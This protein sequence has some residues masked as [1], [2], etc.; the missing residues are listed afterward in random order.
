MGLGKCLE[1]LDL[2]LNNPAVK[3][4]IIIIPGSFLSIYKISSANV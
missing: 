4:I 2:S 1:F 3:C